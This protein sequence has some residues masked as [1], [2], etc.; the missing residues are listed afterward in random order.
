ML[1]QNGERRNRGV[2]VNAFGELAESV[3][4]LGGVT[5]IDAR[6]AKTQGGLLDGNRTFGVP[7]VQV[8]L[9]G[10]WDT[11]FIRGLTLTG[12]AIYTSDFF[13]DAANKL[14]VSDWTRYD[15]GARYTFVGP[16]NNKPVVVRFAVENVLNKNY[17]QG[18]ATDR[19]VFLAAPRTYLLSTTFNF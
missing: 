10:E 11:P 18:T 12:R 13:A 2:E 5:F 16:W 19:Y 8:N 17:W 1:T 9:G 3:R 4:V 15:I 7:D 14:L 6:Q